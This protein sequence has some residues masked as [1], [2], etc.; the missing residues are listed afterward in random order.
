MSRLSHPLLISDILLPITE[1]LLEGAATPRQR[2]EILTNLVLIH[3][4]VRAILVEHAAMWRWVDINSQH[5]LSLFIERAQG[6]SVRPLLWATV[7]TPADI[8]ILDNVAAALGSATPA[9]S[10]E[11]LNLRIDQSLLQVALRASEWEQ[12][13]TVSVA[14]LELAKWDSAAWM[15]EGA[16]LSLDKFPCLESLSIEGATVSLN[17]NEHSSLK[18]LQFFTSYPNFLLNLWPP[19]LS[20][21]SALEVL[22]IRGTFFTQWLGSTELDLPTVRDL[23]ICTTSHLQRIIFR[24]PL[25]ERAAIGASQR[26]T[27]STSLTPSYITSPSH[28]Q[29]TVS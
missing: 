10:P 13:R 19:M 4:R 28:L 1:C 21:F 27:T 8:E 9:L 15:N 23:R 16:Q 29:S 2:G 26:P 3:S 22:D 20:K 7:H 12:V 6:C 14:P 11:A 17:N 18:H 5:Q 25:L 24:A